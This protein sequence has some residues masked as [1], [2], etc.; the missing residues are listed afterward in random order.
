ML[1]QEYIRR[2]TKVRACN[3]NR[4]PQSEQNF[5]P[6]LKIEQRSRARLATSTLCAVRVSND[7]KFRPVA[8]FTQLHALTLVARSYALSVPNTLIHSP[9]FLRVVHNHTLGH[10]NQLPTKPLVHS[11]CFLCVVHNHTLGH[12]NQL[13]T[14]QT[15]CGEFGSLKQYKTI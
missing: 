11:P 7:G 14:K 6:V 10:N 1:C 5:P 3:S 15:L 4:R 2:A 9:C 12:N 13:P 8:I